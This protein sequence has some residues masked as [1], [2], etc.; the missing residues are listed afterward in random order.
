MRKCYLPEQFDA[1]K[2]KRRYRLA[3][4][5][6]RAARINGQWN[7][8]LFVPLPRGTAE[9]IFDAPDPPPPLKTPEDYAAEVVAL[10]APDRSE[11]E[12]A[13]MCDKLLRMIR[14]RPSEE[15][16]R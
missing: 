2:F 9:P 1:E 6:F 12:C 3:D 16:P 13:A 7:V 8:W 15:K 5:D 14:E 11:A 4:S 10:I